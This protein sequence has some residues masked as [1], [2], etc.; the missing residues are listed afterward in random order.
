MRQEFTIYSVKDYSVRKFDE[1]I[2]SKGVN[3]NIDNL[4]SE[5]KKDKSYH[6]RIHKNTTY[7]FFGD[8][9][10][11]MKGIDEFMKCLQCFLSSNYKL[12]FDKSEFKYTENKNKKGSYH[13]SIPKWNALTET[14]KDMHKKFKKTFIKEEQK[15]IDTSIYSEHW[16]RCPLQ[17]K[18]DGTKGLHI[19][20]NGELVDFVV[21]YI[22]DNSVNIDKVMYMKEYESKIDP[23]HINKEDDTIDFTHDDIE[24][25]VNMLS[26]ERCN[27][28]EEWLNVGMCLYN[29]NKTYIHIWRK[30]SQKSPKYEKD[31]CEQKWKSFKKTSEGLKIGSLLLWCKQDNEGKY[32]D[33]IN[34]RKV[35][36]IIALKFPKEN[37]VLGDTIKVNDVCNYIILKNKE[38]LISGGCHNDLPDSMYIEVIKNLMTIKCKHPEC[39]G[40]ALCEHLQLTKQEMNIVFNGNIT[41]NINNKDDELVDFQQ[42]DV[43]ENEE[44]NRLVFRSLNGEAG[45]LAEIVYNK[46]K[47]IYNYGEDDEWY[48]Y[49]HHKWKNIGKKNVNLRHSIEPTLCELYTK[50]LNYY[51]QNDKDKKKIMTIKQI[52]KSFDNTILKNNIM[53]ELIDLYLINNNS[54]RD[55]IKKL[56][57]NKYLI[58][59]DNGVYDLKTF[60]FRKGLTE[61]YITM[62]VNYDYTDEYTEK[63]AGLMKFLEDIQ[64]NK[65]ERDYMMTYISIGLVGNLLELF[66]ILTGTGRNGKS[67]FIELIQDTFGDYSCS[68]SSQMF[69]RIRPDANS[70]DPGLLN[71]LKKKIVITS[72]PEK[73]FKLNTG[74][75]K[76]ITGQDTTT[77]RNCHQNEM[78]NFKANFITLLS[79]NDIPE[80]DDIDIAFSKRL[81][82][83]H[84]PNQFVDNP[85]QE[86]QKLIDVNIN[87]NFKFWKLDFMLLLIEYYKK[88]MT[89]KELK[90]T[91]NILKWTNKYKEETDVYLSFLNE[92]T[93]V[94]ETHIHLIDLYS[95][96]KL[97]F[98]TNE[99]HTKIPNNKEFSKGIKKYYKLELVRIQD[100]VLTGIKKLNLH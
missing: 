48:V 73:G 46:Y 52:M 4:C 49:E 5:L 27:K 70:P 95:S 26:Q 44:L 72:E 37:L 55:F 36:N 23:I 60:E 88:Y 21:D 89:T 25:L 53:T 40:K 1:F 39:F 13:Y 87:E 31:I 82:C 81:R 66:T 20:I 10:G 90:V 86:N 57:G 18:G 34:R 2:L 98:R 83:I 11:Y 43:Y 77:L 3:C 41:I 8:I 96:F 62:S 28:Y 15:I 61:D 58:G 16:F 24:E 71:L 6:F 54:K 59:F 69:T 94:S 64:P 30:W 14:L 17:S 19:P 75:I 22:P 78:I 76:F 65:E 91:D 93:V 29:I 33:F 84:F 50:L 56:D 45:T 63:T 12:S 42:I 92:N 85:I 99:P 51:K 9:D 47:N 7:I 79:C 97:W 67:R 74:F 35:N 38:C 68:I 32:T 80:C 100:K